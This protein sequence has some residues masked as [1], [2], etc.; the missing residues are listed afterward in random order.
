MATNVI[1]IKLF[2]FLYSFD[3]TKRITDIT[4]AKI[5]RTSHES[6]PYKMR[7]LLYSPKVSAVEGIRNAILTEARIEFKFWL[8]LISPFDNKTDM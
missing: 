6:K 7:C 3:L 8:K 4:I 5:D 1:G 2:D